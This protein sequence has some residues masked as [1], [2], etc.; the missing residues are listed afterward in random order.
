MGEHGLSEFVS[1]VVSV[2]SGES[3]SYW[4]L[5]EPFDR[6]L[7]VEDTESEADARDKRRVVIVDRYRGGRCDFDLELV[8]WKVFGWFFFLP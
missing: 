6:F 7:V 5:R 4:K 2:P 8:F 1:E 3:K